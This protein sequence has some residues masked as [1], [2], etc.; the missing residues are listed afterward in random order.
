MDVKLPERNFIHEFQAHHDHARTPEKQDVK[1]HDHQVR[2]IVPTQVIRIGRPSQ[3]RKRPQRRTEP[4]IENIRFRPQIVGSA[5]RTGTG[6][7]F[8]NDHL[9]TL[10]AGPYRNPM[11]PPKLA[12]NAPVV[13]AVHPIEIDLA[14]VFG[15]DADVSLLNRADCG[16]CQRLHPH[17]PLFGQNRFDH[18]LAAA[19][20][21][22]A[23][24][25]FFLFFQK[26]SGAKVVEDL[27]AS[28]VTVH[29]FVRAAILRDARLFIQNPQFRQV[30]ALSYAV[31]IRI[32]RGGYFHSARAK[33]RIDKFIGDDRD[34]AFEQREHK[35]AANGP[36][37]SLIR[38][39]YGDGCIA[40]H[41]FG[42]R[43]GN[44]DITAVLKWITNVPEFAGALFMANFQIAHRGA[45]TGTPI[46]D[47]GTAVNQAFFVK[48][49]KNFEHR[50]G[51]FGVHRE[52]LAR[53]VNGS[54]K[55]LHLL[56]NP[57]AALLLPLPAAFEEFFPPH[58]EPPA[59]AL[60]SPRS[61]CSRTAFKF[62]KRLAPDLLLHNHLRSDCGV[63][64]SRKPQHVFAAHTVP[65]HQ[66]VN[67]RMFE[68]V[69]DVE[70]TS[71]VRWW[72]YEAETRPGW[73]AG[74][75]VEFLLNPHPR[76]VGFNG[77]GRIYF[78]NFCLNA[79]SQP[80]YVQFAAETR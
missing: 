51:V 42:T 12:R 13:N 29:A 19:A 5:L 43:C 77:F 28:F 68:H 79:H 20:N 61:Q 22:D 60:S 75:P 31:V 47:V 70:R 63:V 24:S 54:A 45:A 57:A 53:P 15:N 2:W 65:S 1:T 14:V 3:R 11:A 7:S 32:V 48:P 56:T 34:H 52:A 64:G 9:A 67:L 50:A 4:C 58:F 40:E 62:G 46:D 33:V 55:A 25:V 27:F 76:P 49:R 18:G 30:V 80:Q 8:R 39:I 41:R 26:A 69:P 36:A 21:T 23:E 35:P 38:G 44:G 78:G 66:N 59:L 74:R 73:V 10:P 71:D 72:N 37:I 17:K 16:L 6:R